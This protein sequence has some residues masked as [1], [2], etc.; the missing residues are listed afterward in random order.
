[1]RELDKIS[2]ALF[3]KI[4]ARF[5]HVNIGDENAQRVTDPES[6]RFFNFDYISENGQNFGNVTISLIDEDSIKVYFGSNI[7]DALDEEQETEWYKFLRALREFARRNM[8]SFDVRDIN[9]S[10]LDLKDIKQQS[11]SDATYDKEELTI[12]EGK[13]YGHGNNR[14]I[15]FG[16]VGTHKLIIKHRDQIDP[17]RHGSRARQIEHLFIE[18]PIGE[19]FLLDHNNLHGARATA[20]HLRHGGNIG[21]EGS[22]LINE[23]VKEMA[24]MRH[25]VRSMKNRT[26]E[27]AETSGMV[28]AA[29]HRYNEVRDHL[30]RF[31]G[32]QGHELLMN[33][34]GQSQ[35]LDE[36][37]V[38]SLRE[39]FVK[40]I[41][42]DRFNEALPYVYRAYKNK[43]KMD[44]PMTLEFESWANEISEQT[45]DD[46]TDDRDEQNL[47]ALMQAP[48][49]VGVDAADAIAAISSIDFLKSDDLHQALI[50]LSKNQGPDADARRTIIGWLASNGENALANQFMQIMQ[51]QNAN[52][53]PAPP[54]PVPQPQPVG[55]TTMDQPVVQEDLSFLRRLAGLK[56]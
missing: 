26:F 27:D 25:F 33:M 43:Q 52:T 2:A 40:K 17:D 20:N 7:T 11:V 31:Q 14:R 41:Y 32:R 55:A 18:T 51:Q 54:Q 10:N 45:W 9:R 44:T 34:C 12:A 46:D 5:N 39:R 1:M 24:S 37:D 36:V 47:N 30:K 15:S 3:D 23:M 50:K 49:A 42:D 28:E 16:D 13:L 22:Q 19:R 21:D 4:R 38:D 48:I 8:L 35:D 56:F 6:A 29:I 53:Q